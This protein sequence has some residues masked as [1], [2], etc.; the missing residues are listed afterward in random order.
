[1]KKNL[2]VLAFLVLSSSILFAQTNTT[3][4]FSANFTGS[5]AV[6]ANPAVTTATQTVGGETLSISSAGGGN[7]ALVVMDELDYFGWDIPNFSGNVFSIDIMED[8]T[9]KLTLS[10]AGG[11]NFDLAGFTILETNASPSTSLVLTTSKGSVVTT[12]SSDD[13]QAK[14]QTFN[15]PVLKGVNSVTITRQGGGTFLISLDNIVLQN[16]GASILPLR[17]LSFTGKQTTAGNL[18]TW[19]TAAETGM[20]EFSVEKLLGGTSY[21]AI[22]SVNAGKED[23]QFVDR[24]AEGTCF[25]RLK[26]IDMD[27]AYRYSPVIAVRGERELPATVSPNPVRGNTVRFQLA[28]RISGNLQITVVDAAGRAWYT[29]VVNADEPGNIKELSLPGLPA[30]MYF[31][32]VGDKAAGRGEVVPFQKQ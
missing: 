12:F 29:G 24:N 18:L 26:M 23:Y 31:L 8:V 19:K 2:L 14:V 3:F 4:N 28:S 17:L 21:T 22:G 32:Q 13:I 25:Y 16:I 20:R 7:G 9:H 30:G 1:M 15:N 5:T 6:G 10:V 11:K 27:G